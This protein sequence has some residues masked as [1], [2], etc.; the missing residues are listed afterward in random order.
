V[1]KH[2]I[3]LFIDKADKAINEEDF[4]TVVDLYA[5]DAV[6]V[7]KPGTNAVGKA[8]TIA[9]FAPSTTPMVMRSWTPEPDYSGNWTRRPAAPA[10]GRRWRCAGKLA[11]WASQRHSLALRTER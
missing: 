5:E 4:D 1:N 9:G 10:S 2:P 11:L 3:A 8:V 7:I 6:L